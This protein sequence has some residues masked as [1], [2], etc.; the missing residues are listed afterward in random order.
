MRHRGAIQLFTVQHRK[1][2]NLLHDVTAMHRGAGTT[3][4]FILL[5]RARRSSAVISLSCRFSKAGRMSR[6]TMLFRMA[7]CCQPF[8]HPQATFRSSGNSPIE[9]SLRIGR[10]PLCTGKPSCRRET[11]VHEQS[12]AIPR[13][14]HIARSRQ[15]TPMQG[16]LNSAANRACRSLSSGPVIFPRMPAIIRLRCGV[17]GSFMGGWHALPRNGG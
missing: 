17:V 14:N 10:L 6:S 7:Q 9:A 15:I 16:D 2:I 3:R 5:Q 13:E 4:T 12:S 1:G 8:E 11:S